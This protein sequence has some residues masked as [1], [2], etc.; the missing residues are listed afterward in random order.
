MKCSNY[1][2]LFSNRKSRRTKGNHL[3]WH[4]V[5]QWLWYNEINYLPDPSGTMYY[6]QAH[7]RKVQDVDVWLLGPTIELDR[8]VEAYLNWAL[9]KAMSACVSKDNHAIEKISKSWFIRHEIVNKHL[10]HNSLWWTSFWCNKIS[11]SIVKA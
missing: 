5:L 1:I 6:F 10:M 4:I 11:N 2:D 7:E 3:C 9:L 8:L